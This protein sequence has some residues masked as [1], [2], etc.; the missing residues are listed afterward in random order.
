MLVG[1]KF[2]IKFEEVREDAC[3]SMRVRES[4]SGSVNKKISARFFLD[5][6]GFP[7]FW[8]LRNFLPID[9]LTD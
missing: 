9:R 3:R 2:E 6:F 1:S 4:V 5:F 8:F 7:L